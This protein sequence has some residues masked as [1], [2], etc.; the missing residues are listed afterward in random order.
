MAERAHL[1]GVQLRPHVKTHKTL[2]AVP[3]QVRDHFGGITVSTLAE[4][5]FYASRGIK[6][7]TYAVPITPHK[8]IRA[9]EISRRIDHLNVLV[10]HQ[11]A[12]DA[13]SQSCRDQQHRLDVLLK[14][15]CGYGRAG[16]TVEDP[17]LIQLAEK[18]TSDQWLNFAGILTHAGHS[19]HCKNVHE[20]RMIAHD[21]YTSIIRARE[22]LIARGLSVPIVSL[23][24]TPTA[25]VF[26][27]LTGVTEMRPGN[28]VFFDLFQASIGSCLLS[29]IALSV[30][31]EIIAYYPRRGEILIDAG[32]L[33]L[34]K[35]LGAN[36][37]EN[38][39]YGMVCD[40]NYRPLTQLHLV[41]LSQEHGKIMADDGFDFSALSL[42]MR[43]RILPNHSCLVSALHEGLH[44]ARGDELFDVWT[45]TRGW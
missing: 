27:S 21:E 34:S 14:V 33:A 22:L 5:E 1:L 40:L 32:S 7:I 26:D 29:S 11:D 44:V 12:V 31:T 20:I 16:I 37:P 8:I 17:L 24:S 25:Q 13:L 15:D 41:N 35:D 42:G 43:L 30:I 18:I 38:T 45:P 23:G 9:I 3:Y 19:Y 39:R 6:N 4:A 28:Y 10:D 36:S 2:E